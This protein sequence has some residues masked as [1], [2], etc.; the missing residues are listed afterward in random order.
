MIFSTGGQWSH[1]QEGDKWLV[2]KW[3]KQRFVILA[4]GKMEWSHEVKET[5]NSELY[6]FQTEWAAESQ[7]R[8]CNRIE[9]EPS[10]EYFATSVESHRVFHDRISFTKPMLVRNSVFPVGTRHAQG[11]YSWIGRVL[12]AFW[13]GWGRNDQ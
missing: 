11:F 12:K 5:L 10:L 8:F 2:G 6:E 1:R 13:Y 3:S 9:E 4:D 7:A